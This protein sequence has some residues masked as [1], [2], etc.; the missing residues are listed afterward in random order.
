MTPIQTT[1][2]ASRG[3]AITTSLPVISIA[4]KTAAQSTKNGS[5]NRLLGNRSIRQFYVHI[6][7]RPRA[8]MIP[9]LVT[10]STSCPYHGNVES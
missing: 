3:T 7:A 5:L 4:M 8:V 6:Q 1:D 2:T 9:R 10:S